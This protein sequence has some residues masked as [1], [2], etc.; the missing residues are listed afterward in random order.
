MEL[1]FTALGLLCRI[2]GLAEWY[3]TWMKQRAAAKQ[4]QAV[5]NVPTTKE[6]LDERLKD[7]QF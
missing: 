7:H 5:A 6:E 1:A 2:I 3:E 4:A